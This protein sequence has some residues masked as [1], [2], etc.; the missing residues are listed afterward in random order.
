MLT[1]PEDTQRHEAEHVGQ[2]IGGQGEQCV[3]QIPFGMDRYEGGTR[4]SST[5]SV[6]AKAKTPSLSE[7]R[8]STLRP[9]I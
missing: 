2:Q 7:P 4:R 8:R 1:D 3:L 5:S 6:I 9:A